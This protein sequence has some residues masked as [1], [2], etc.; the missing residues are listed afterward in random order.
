M[1][2]QWI[3]Y[4][5]KFLRALRGACPIILFFLIS[6]AAVY[7]LSG[8]QYVI[9][10]SVL[11]VF[12]QI[13]HKQNNNTLLRYIRLV[14]IG[15]L[16]VVMAYISSLSFAA[17]VLLNLAIPFILV[18]TQ[19]SQFNPKGYFSYAMIF[20]FLSLMPPENVS[21]LWKELIAFWC[22]TLFL[23]ASMPSTAG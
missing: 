2:D 16:L 17:C 4:L 13:R 7:K 19:S 3:V 11:T 15:G 8:L 20:V 14:V 10:A 18:F 5:Q 9:V 21:G 6:F 23:A 1:A 22:C 12:F